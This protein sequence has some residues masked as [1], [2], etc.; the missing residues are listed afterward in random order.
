MAKPLKHAV[1]EY[2]M[3]LGYEIYVSGGAGMSGAPEDARKYL[4]MVADRVHAKIN[5]QNARRWIV[6]V[7]ARFEAVWVMGTSDIPKTC[8]RRLSG[9]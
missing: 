7:R 9:P 6:T 8:V 1:Y 2:I 4:R 3:P 5:D